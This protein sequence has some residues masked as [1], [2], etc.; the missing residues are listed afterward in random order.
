MPGLEGHLSYSFTA[1]LWASLDASYAFRGNTVVDG[2]D[3]NDSQKNLTIGTEASWSPNPRNS[4]AFV[5]AKSVVH[6]NAPAY[7]GIA[8]K[9]FCTW[10]HGY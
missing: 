5:L 4:M 3:Q 9:Y 2:V 8:I 6:E 10:G 1:D 7:T